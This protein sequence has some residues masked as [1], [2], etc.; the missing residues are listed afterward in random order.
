MTGTEGLESLGLIR[1][2]CMLVWSRLDQLH[3]GT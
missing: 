3:L 1:I 2:R